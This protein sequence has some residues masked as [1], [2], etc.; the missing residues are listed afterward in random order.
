MTSTSPD[1]HASFSGPAEQS[2]KWQSEACDDNMDPGDQADDLPCSILDH[3]RRKL[4][5]QH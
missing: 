3:Y 5:Y 1:G 4:P 2:K